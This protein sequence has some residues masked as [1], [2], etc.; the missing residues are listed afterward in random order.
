MSQNFYAKIFQRIFD[1]SLADDYRVRHLFMDLL[2]LADSEGRIDMTVTA[3][4]RRTGIPS[5]EIQRFI[6]LLSQP[7]PESTSTAEGGRRLVP[8]ERKRRWGWRIVNYTKYREITASEM[9]RM[10][11]AERKRL[12]RMNAIRRQAGQPPMRSLPPKK[13]SPTPLSKPCTE[14]EGENKKK[15]ESGSGTVRTCPGH[16]PDKSRTSSP[17]LSVEDSGKEADSQSKT[18]SNAERIGTEK[19]LKYALA[20]LQRIRDRYE[21]K[22]D[23]EEKDRENAARLKARIAVLKTSI[24]WE[25]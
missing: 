16:V 15:R 5:E 19:E 21:T 7:D 17:P 1:S 23:W 4:A 24:G 8:L 11:D 3:I 9:M 18:L 22:E 20:E 13:V 10:G 12:Y 25:A 2:L 6:D 14:E